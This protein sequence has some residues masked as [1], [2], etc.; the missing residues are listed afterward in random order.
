M[1]TAEDYKFH[2]RDTK[3]RTW[4]ETLF[5][6]FSVPEAGISASVYTLTRPNLGVCHSSIEIHKG[7]CFHPWQIHHCDSQMHLPCPENFA[8]FSLD[9]GLSFK[10]HNARDLDFK[11]QSRD[12]N[13]A[14][15]LTYRSICDPIDPHDPKD[16]PQVSSAK[17]KGYDGWNTGHL[18]GKGHVTGELLLRGQKYR[19]DCV[20]GTNKSWGP[21][22]DWGNKGATWVHIDLDEDFSAFLVLGLSFKNKEVVY[23]PFNYGYIASK[24]KRRPII[25]ASMTAQ[26]LDMLVTRATV[27]LRDD[28]GK[29]YVAHG[30]TI[31]GAPWYSFN[32]ASAGFQTLMRWECDGRTGHSHIAD[33]CG[34]GFLSQGMADEFAT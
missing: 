17:V 18:E 14:F 11:Y 30:T 29:T 24:G 31:A 5:V 26:R 21:R 22:N 8:D 1:I 3:D 7:F 28:Q 13:C 4:T 33:F 27:E 32:P 20:E 2:E 16:N 19:I 6:I 10:A 34:I 9:N 12:G 23:G 15:D 25:S